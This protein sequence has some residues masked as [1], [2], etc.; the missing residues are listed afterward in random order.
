MTAGQLQVVHDAAR[1]VAGQ[2]GV[3][4]FDD[5]AIYN[6]RCMFGMARQLIRR[7]AQTTRLRLRPS[8]R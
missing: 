1:A 8:Q 3:H 5:F 2:P 4:V 7:A 6:G